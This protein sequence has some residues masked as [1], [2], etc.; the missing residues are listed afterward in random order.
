VR[1]P[2]LLLL[3]LLPLLLSGCW[4]VKQGLGQLDL[5]LNSRALEDVEADPSFTAEQRRKIALVREVKAFGEREIGLK[6]SNNYT[7]FYDTRGKPITWVVTACARDRF[8]PHT[9]W[10]PIVGTVPYKGFFSREDARGEARALEEAGLDVAVAPA[11]AYSTL[12]WFNDPVLSTMLGYEDEDLANLILH[13]LTHGTVFVPGDVD[14]N[15]GLASFV[16]ARGSIDFFRARDGA[17]SPSHA[18]A[19][20]AMAREERRDVRAREL[21]GALDALYRSDASPEDKLALREEIA[22]ALR[23]TWAAEAEALMRGLRETLREEEGSERGEGEVDVRD[24]AARLEMLPRVA[25]GPVN[26]AVILS[27]RRYGRTEEFRK[28]FEDA[29]RDWRRFLGGVA[30]GP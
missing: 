11:A 28:R 17:D 3:P 5:L 26:N 24:A 8:E 16:G 13:E 7:R 14:F 10:F 12:G 22:A 2:A 15:E 6:P 21:Y 20:R 23:R 29:G 4:Y 9:W 30:G 18:R 25:E 27:Q 19:A 1:R